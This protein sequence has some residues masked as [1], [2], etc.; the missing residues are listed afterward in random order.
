MADARG[1]RLVVVGGG[2]IGSALALLG[3]RRGYEVA[4]IERELD[5]RGAS[6]RNFGLVWVSGRPPGAELAF[7]LRSR[8]L[9][10]QLAAEVPAVGFRASGSLTI[11]REEPELRVLEQVV[12][13]ADAADRRLELLDAAAT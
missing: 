7:A 1:A 4:H 11:V 12:E 2:V 8:E 10:E 3:L 9:W 13:R 5:A 6:V